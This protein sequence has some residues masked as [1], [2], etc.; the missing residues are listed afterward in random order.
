M[1]DVSMK[2]ANEAGFERFSSPKTCPS[3]GQKSFRHSVFRKHIHRCCPDLLMISKHTHSADGT[4]HFESERDVEEWL[5]A[6]RAKELEL[7]KKALDIAFRQR[8]EDDNPIRQGP[9]EIARAIGAIDVSRAQKLLKSAMKAIPLAA[10]YDPIDVIYDDEH[11][12]GLNKPPFVITAPKHR[13]TGGS[14]VNRVIGNMGIEPLVVHRL[15]MNTT[16]VVIFAKSSKAASL[17]H[18]QFRE[19]IPQKTYL[20]LVLGTPDWTT[21]TVDAPIGESAIEKVARAITE[22]GKPAVTDFK[23]LASSQHADFSSYKASPCIDPET[24]QRYRSCRTCSLIECRPR[25][26]K[27][28]QIRVHLAHLGHCILGDDLYGITGPCISRHALHAAK[29]SLKHPSHDNDAFQVEAPLPEDFQSAMKALGF[30][31]MAP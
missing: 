20:A 14:L 30:H 24:E 27:T 4:A 5:R 10:D 6:A 3:C 18:K 21:T 28:H 15:D 25:T 16:G 9:E 19:K 26:G 17:L 1:A 22:D 2:S 8:D 11:I 31:A 23:V 7:H 12:I 29:L 13:Y